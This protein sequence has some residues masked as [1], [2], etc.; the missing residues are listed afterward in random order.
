MISV[1]GKFNTFVNEIVLFYNNRRSQGQDGRSNKENHQ[2][3]AI[4]RHASTPCYSKF[5]ICLVEKILTMS[6]ILY[7]IT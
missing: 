3:A 2:H 1:F 6:L 7:T 5:F 4:S